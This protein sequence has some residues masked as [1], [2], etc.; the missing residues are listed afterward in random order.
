MEIRFDSLDQLYEN[1]TNEEAA[2]KYI[3]QIRWRHGMYCPK[4]GSPGTRRCRPVVARSGQS[5]IDAGLPILPSDN[6]TPRSVSATDVLR[7][8][9]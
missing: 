9:R 7:R 6:G 1:I 2:H 5:C 4:C 3:A 8:F